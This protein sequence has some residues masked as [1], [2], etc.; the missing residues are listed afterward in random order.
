MLPRRIS[1]PCQTK[2]SHR[3]APSGWPDS[4]LKH[5]DPRGCSLQCPVDPRLDLFEQMKTAKPLRAL[6]DFVPHTRPIGVYLASPSSAG[7][8]AWAV[9]QLLGA[10]HRAGQGRIAQDTLTTHMTPEDG[11]LGSMFSP[12]ER[13]TNGR[14]AQKFPRHDPYLLVR[15]YILIL[16]PSHHTVNAL[17]DPQD[18]GCCVALL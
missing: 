10:V 4:T 17:A 1:S 13:P 9:S 18:V 15:I 16:Q 6:V 3:S 8:S 5:V 12:G 11:L 7:T 2:A 14:M